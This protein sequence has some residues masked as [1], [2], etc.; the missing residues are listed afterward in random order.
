MGFHFLYGTESGTAELL[1]EDME[2]AISGDHDTQVS[3]LEEVTPSDL[4]KN[5]IYIMVCST[6]GTGDLPASATAFYASLQN[7]KP[8]LSGVTFAIFGLGDMTYSETFNQG[9][10]KLMTELKALGA[11]QIGDRGLFDASEPDMPEDV[12]VPWLHGIVA[13]LAKAA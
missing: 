3:N 11:N 9:S 1:A 7:D 8:N 10:E 12:A 4:N 6:Y 5:D 13:Q 2:A